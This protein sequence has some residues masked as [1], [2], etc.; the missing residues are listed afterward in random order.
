MRRLD[1]TGRLVVASVGHPSRQHAFRGAYRRT[2]RPRRAPWVH[3]NLASSSSCVFIAAVMLGGCGAGCDSQTLRPAIEHPPLAT[4]NHSASQ[5]TFLLR[6]HSVEIERSQASEDL[7]RYRIRTSLERP[8]GGSGERTVVESDTLPRLR[9]ADALI[10]AVFTMATHELGENAVSAL[11]GGP[12]ASPKAC[13]CFITGEKWAYVWT[14]DTAY[15]VD[16]GLAIVAPERSA[17][18][19]EFKISAPKDA[20]LPRWHLVQDTGTGGSWPISTDRVLLGW[21]AASM[22]PLV[23]AQQRAAFRSKVVDA[24]QTAV[25]DAVAYTYDSESGLFQGEQSFLDWRHQTYPLW[26]DAADIGEAKS[27]STNVAHY[28]LLKTAASLRQGERQGNPS[29]EA[30]DQGEAWLKDAA[31]LRDA[32]R[33][34]FWDAEHG[35]LR[36][37][38]GPIRVP[39]AWAQQE[40]LGTS[41]AILEDILEPDEARAALRNYPRFALG[42][43]VVFPVYP[44][45][46]IYHNR[47]AWPFVSAYA[48]LAAAKVSLGPVMDHEF[49]WLT[50]SAALNL[51]HLENYDARSGLAYIDDGDVRG[52]IINSPRQLWSVAGYI[53]VIARG[54]FGVHVEADG[55]TFRPAVTETLRQRLS[56]ETG[57]SPSL[58]GWHPFDADSRVALSFPEERGATYTLRS[59]IADGDRFSP[60]AVIPGHARHVTLELEPGATHSA[61]LNFLPMDDRERFMAPSDPETPLADWL[62]ETTLTVTLPAR[63][64]GETYRVFINGQR[65]LNAQRPG[66]ITFR[67]QDAAPEIACVAVEAVGNRG[68]VSH[69]SDAICVTR[70]PLAPLT[71]E[72]RTLTARGGRLER[73][74]DRWM[75]NAWGDPTDTLRTPRFSVP[76]SG[77]YTVQLRGRN[78]GSGSSGITACSKRIVVRSGE[79]AAGPGQHAV[80][81]PTSDSAP[82]SMQAPVMSST[83]VAL[84]LSAGAVYE[85]EL[86][87]GFNMSYLSLMED[88]S[89]GSGASERSVNHC[90]I[91]AIEV[92]PTF[93]TP[94]VVP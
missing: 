37:L 90:D 20:A 38:R 77:R 67:W 3:A 57:R 41:L 8:L 62:D 16:L 36:A 31:R 24:V 60:D 4:H 74:G 78:T 29:Q 73:E 80:A 54:I 84:D 19:V 68:L 47:G 76:R 46:D 11:V 34:G 10:D 85:L 18:S 5:E 50:E 51:S 48:F 27:L 35:V 42:S 15:A 17:A 86:S 40:L 66:V 81:L 33:D 92:R 71:F 12:H 44:G 43:P 59:I 72:A 55:F 45:R 14:R 75:L 94:R 61:P 83:R 64:E 6:E 39:H 49:T 28:L 70:D 13:D 9:S 23:P 32:I 91:Q 69:P 56:G 1:T 25:G 87:D 58:L 7:W 63:P 79:R 53:G 88:F 30:H 82:G 26:T 22:V 93:T 65:R 21:A 52:P 2:T 89:W